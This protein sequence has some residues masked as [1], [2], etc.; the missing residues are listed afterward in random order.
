MYLDIDRG[1]QI[2]VQVS[3]YWTRCADIGQVVRIMD[4][5]FGYK[6]RRPAFWIS[7]KCLDIGLGV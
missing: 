6:T 7:P 2:L 5:E 1:V 4:L 3:G